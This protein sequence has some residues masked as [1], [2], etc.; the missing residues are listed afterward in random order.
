MLKN[1][2]LLVLNFME[3]IHGLEAPVNVYIDTCVCK[4]IVL[5]NLTR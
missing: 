1:N 4:I 2:P 3:D 5:R